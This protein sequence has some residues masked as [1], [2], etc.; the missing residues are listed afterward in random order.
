MKT[1]HVRKSTKI[2]FF[3]NFSMPGKLFFSS[4]VFKE[5]MK[6]KQVRDLILKVLK[7]QWKLE[8]QSFYLRKP[9]SS[10]YRQKLTL[11]VRGQV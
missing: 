10:C 6:T 7:I 1:T 4:L 5:F 8:R 11:K 3:L 2:I 9:N